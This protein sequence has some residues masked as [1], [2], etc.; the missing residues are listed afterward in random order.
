MD[1]SHLKNS[2][3]VLKWH[4]V[5]I[6]LAVDPFLLTLLLCLSYRLRVAW[7]VVDVHDGVGRNAHPTAQPILTYAAFSAFIPFSRNS[8][9]IE[10]SVGSLTTSLFIKLICQTAH[11][12][13]KTEQ[14]KSRP[15]SLR[16]LGKHP[17]SLSR[18]LC[19]TFPVW[20]VNVIDTQAYRNF[21]NHL[22]MV[23]YSQLKSRGERVFA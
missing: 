2:S 11:H 14:R 23:Y 6:F 16:L 17:K 8:C 3:E 4:H 1:I 7:P 5:N 21:L 20:E 13:A 9:Q 12:K 22:F 19:L 18:H 10:A 15:R